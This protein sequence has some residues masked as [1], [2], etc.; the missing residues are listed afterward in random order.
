MEFIQA[1]E[2]KV[3]QSVGQTTEGARAQA[4]DNMAS[5]AVTHLVTYG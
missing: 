1:F 2:R 4:K 5:S 3:E